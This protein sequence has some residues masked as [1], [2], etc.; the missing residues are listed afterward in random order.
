MKFE[1]IYA[2]NRSIISFELFPPRTDAGMRTLEERLPRL[3]DLGPDLLTVTYGAMGS[4]RERTLEVASKIKNEYGV[5]AAHH[6][7]CVGLSRSEISLA[8][9]TIASHN[10]ENIVALRGDPP[11]GET[12]FTPPPDGYGHAGELV[13]HIAGNYDTGIAVAGYPEKHIE[14]PDFETDLANLKRKADSG[15]DVIITQLFYNNQDFY[16]FVDQC[17]NIGISLPIVPGLMPILRT[18]QIKRITSMC[19]ATIP[20]RLLEKLEGAGDDEEKV[21]RIGIDHT[22]EQALDLLD[23][24]VAGIHFYVLNQHFHIA[25]IMEQ[26][27]P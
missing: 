19:G 20:A 4:T 25:E 3:I 5:E 22:T 6:F 23:H 24:G 21:Y 10:I 18:D 13:E 15:A 17:R 9:E 2:Q 26:I 14:A 1:A 27:R 8:L 11:R 16:R 7:T 12:M